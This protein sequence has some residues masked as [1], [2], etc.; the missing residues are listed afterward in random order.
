VQCRSLR[1]AVACAALL[2]V[3][4]VIAEQRRLFRVGSVERPTPTAR[5][6]LPA[7]RREFTARTRQFAVPVLM[8]HRITNLTAT[9]ARRPLLRD[10]TVSPAAFEQQL[11]Y[12]VEHGFTLLLAREVEEA[13]RQGLALPEKAVAV[14]LDD[15]Y[16]DNFERAFPI[17]RRFGLPATIYLVTG[18]VGTPNHLSWEEVAIMHRE[19]VGYG[20]HSVRHP[21]LTLLSLPELDRELRE[22]KRVLEERLVERISAVA[23]P[24]GRYN[25]RVA[26]RARA[27]GYLAGWKKGGGPVQPGDDPF[28][29]PRVRVRGRTTL[30]DFRRKVW[31]GVYTLAARPRGQR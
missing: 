21:D 9:E 14:T 17:L 26:A 31:S 30:G 16:R 6:T 12:L 27:A 19:Q 22:S 20:S 10:L 1:R 7:A 3:I 28:L 5:V 18:A 24:A 2:A 8:Y 13:V 4:G 25:Q 15:G 23:Y 11:R 29:L